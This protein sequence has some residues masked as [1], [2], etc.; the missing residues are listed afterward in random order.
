[1]RAMQTTGSEQNVDMTDNQ[2]KQVHFKRLCGNM[3]NGLFDSMTRKLNGCSDIHLTCKV[4]EA[5]LN[6]NDHQTLEFDSVGNPYCAANISY[7]NSP[8]TSTNLSSWKSIY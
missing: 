6:P 3:N 8:R 7:Q 1:M 4:V 2:I 5:S